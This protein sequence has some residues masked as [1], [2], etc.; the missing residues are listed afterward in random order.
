MHSA[1]ALAEHIYLIMHVA[2]AVLRLYEAN[3][4]EHMKSLL[5]TGYLCLIIGP[6]NTIMHHLKAFAND[7]NNT[8][9]AEFNTE[10]SLRCY[11]QG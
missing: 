5:N 4:T 10:I 9:I 2:G 8:T 11:K 3:T 6:A 7:N 1:L